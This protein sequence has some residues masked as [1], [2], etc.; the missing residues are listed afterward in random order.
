MAPTAVGSLYNRGFVSTLPCLQLWTPDVD[1]KVLK[2]VIQHAFIFIYN[3]TLL[4][5][6]ESGQDLN[7]QTQLAS[8][9]HGDRKNH[10]F[11]A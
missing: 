5:N 8:P 9:S 2:S 7:V 11:G 10:A 3:K 6:A 4:Q 1:S